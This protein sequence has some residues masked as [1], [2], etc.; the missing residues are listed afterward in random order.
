VVSNSENGDP[1]P[2]LLTDTYVV[3]VADENE[4]HCPC[5]VSYCRFAS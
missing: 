1:E 3:D 5:K 4:D 2:I